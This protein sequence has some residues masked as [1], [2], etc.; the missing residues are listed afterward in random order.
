AT[1]R[2][3]FGRDSARPGSRGPAPWS[4]SDQCGAE[5]NVRAERRGALHYTG[6]SMSDAEMQQVADRLEAEDRLTY[7]TLGAEIRAA[8]AAVDN[9]V[10]KRLYRKARSRDAGDSVGGNPPAEG[11]EAPHLPVPVREAI[12]RLEAAI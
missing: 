4:R 2:R 8:G 10:L 5:Q 7:R 3:R 12:S 6:G 1:T 11:A 9:N